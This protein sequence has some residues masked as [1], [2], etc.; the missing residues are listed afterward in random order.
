MLYAIIAVICIIADQ[1]IKY[2]TV[3]HITLS[4]GMQKLIPGFIHMTYLQN[5]GAAFSFM[6]DSSA[7][8]IV[9]VILCVVVCAVL[10]VLMVKGVLSGKGSR[11][12]AV[13]VMAGAVGNAI[14][15]LVSGYVVDMFEFEFFTFPVFNLADIFI[16]VGGVLFCVF[17][18]L[19]G[20]TP[21]AKKIKDT[22]SEDEAEEPEAEATPAVKAEKPRREKKVKSSG[23]PEKDEQRRKIKEYTPAPRKE[24]PAQKAMDQNDPF[25]EWERRI[26]MQS[27]PMQEAKKEEPDTATR[28]FRAVS[29][30][31][32]AAQEAEAPVQEA[33]RAKHVAPEA[34]AEVKAPEASAAPAAA[35]AP[36][37]AVKDEFDIDSILAEFGSGE[38][39]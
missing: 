37:A 8:R 30:A 27:E 20:R 13:F 7:S 19:E 6:A 39:F 12:C 9:F 17:V 38:D 11:W 2:Y 33:P 29:D 22:A 32:A 5:K 1:L 23:D 4:T 18:L 31:P 16:T 21:K 10:I 35:E 24:R 25:A 34:P 36:K 15:R 26:G 3:A 28:I 14:D